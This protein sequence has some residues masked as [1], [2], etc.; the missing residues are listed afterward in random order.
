MALKTEPFQDDFALKL[1]GFSS[2]QAF[3]GVVEANGGFAVC[4]GF[5]YVM[6]PQLDVQRKDV[7]S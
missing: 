6:L 5:S 1:F 3:A 7:E 4:P 2:R